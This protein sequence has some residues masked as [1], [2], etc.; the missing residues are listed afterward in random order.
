MLL[1]DIFYYN[2]HG[3]REDDFDRNVPSSYDP[4]ISDGGCAQIICTNWDGTVE[5]VGSPKA[6]KLA[7][8]QERLR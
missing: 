4:P 3:G 1:Y 5:W 7:Q 6:I 2:E 8:E